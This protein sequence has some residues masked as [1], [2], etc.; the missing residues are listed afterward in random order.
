MKYPMF[1]RSNFQTF[2]IQVSIADRI[3]NSLLTFWLLKLPLQTKFKRT[4]SIL[5]N[6]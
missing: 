1:S 2:V 4:D 3:V 5:E 6:I